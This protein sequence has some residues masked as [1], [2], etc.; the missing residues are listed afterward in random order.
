MKKEIKR[1]ALYEME[2]ELVQLKL[3]QPG[4][5]LLLESSI[6]RFYKNQKAEITLMHDGIDKIRRQFIQTDGAGNF[7]TEQ[8]GDD[9]D[10][11]YVNSYTDFKAAQTYYT[12]N[13]IKKVFGEKV[14]EFLNITINV[15][16]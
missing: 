12:K 4:L 5:A 15:I 10:W 13:E 16:V 3:Q 14:K 9:E 8:N 7:L 6:H 1:G 11:K 2:S